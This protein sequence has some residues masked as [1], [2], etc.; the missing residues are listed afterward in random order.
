MA[1][2]EIRAFCKG[3]K[4]TAITETHKAV[5]GYGKAIYLEFDG[6]SIRVKPESDIQDLIEIMMLKEKLK[7]SLKE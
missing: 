4:M 6:Y 5:K 7:D 3:D 2:V 1:H